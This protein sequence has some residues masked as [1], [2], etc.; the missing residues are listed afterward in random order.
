MF[1][2]A[3][4]RH[5]CVP[6]RDTAYGVSIHSLISLSKTFRRISPTRNIAQTWI[7]ATL[8][9]YSSSFSSLILDF[10]CWMVLIAVWRWK[11]AI[12]LL[13]QT[14]LWHMVVGK[15]IIIPALGHKNKE[16]W[17]SEAWLAFV[18]MSQCGN[19]NELAHHHVPCD[20]LL[21]KAYDETINHT[22]FLFQNWQWYLGPLA[23]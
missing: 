11:P 6:Q 3:A 15:L 22:I 7:F 2:L 5:I 16:T 17:T 18:L 23:C 13:Q 21:Q 19:N 10:I 9:E 12:G 8:V 20:R 1:L 14:I 4:G